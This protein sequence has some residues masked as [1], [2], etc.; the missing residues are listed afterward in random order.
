MVSIFYNCFFFFRFLSFLYLVKRY[1]DLR[2]LF[3]HRCYIHPSIDDLVLWGAITYSQRE[4]LQKI[5]IFLFSTPT[6][7]C[8]YSLSVSE[9]RAALTLTW[10]Y[11]LK[12][13]E[14]DVRPFWLFH[15]VGPSLVWA[16][17]T[18]WDSNQQVKGW[19]LNS[20]ALHIEHL[21]ALLCTQ[22]LW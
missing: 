19:T 2:W 18:A 15:H 12:G 9:L 20:V 21:H 10:P 8:R 11:V 7:H 16:L 6:M 14:M 17:G 22:D 1:V 3:D 4:K 13:V 5:I